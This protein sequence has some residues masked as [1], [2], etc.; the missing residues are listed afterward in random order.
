MSGSI[1]IEYIACPGR[2][3]ST[4]VGSVLGLAPGRVF[5]GELR[6]VWREGL[7]ENQP[8]GCGK[9]FRDCDFWQQVFV[10][11]FGGFDAPGAVRLA[12][13]LRELDDRSSGLRGL[14]EVWQFRRGTGSVPDDLQ[15]LAR[16]YDAIVAVS[17]A[18]VVVDSS[19]SLRYAA[20]LA[21]TPGLEPRLTNLIRDPRGL[22]ASRAKR[23]LRRDGSERSNVSS[24]RRMRIVR[25]VAKWALRNALA[26]RV[27]R[28]D[29]GIRL[30]YEEFVRDQGWYLA[31]ALGETEAAAVERRLL[32]GVGPELVQ[33]QLGGN[34]VR[35]LKISPVER[36]RTDLPLLPRLI[37]GAL[38]APFRA[39][40]RSRLYRPHR[41]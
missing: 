5:V 18:T 19:K 36:W 7:T 31:A 2:S 39:F 24:A 37:A 14:R 41:Q 35:G 28:R 29:G 3:G 16:L 20:L 38:S 9:S 34:W 25:T 30:I 32:Q 1:P 27:M 13:M 4:L 10:R 23:A 21:A 15:P 12:K 22:I 17:G 8:C 26:A 6:G 40:Y 11:A 33:H